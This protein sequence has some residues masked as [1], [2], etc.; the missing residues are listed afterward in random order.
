[1]VLFLFYELNYL[2]PI[3]MTEVRAHVVLHQKVSLVMTITSDHGAPYYADHDVGFDHER[4]VRLS[5]LLSIYQYHNTSRYL[6]D[7]VF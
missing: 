4:F 7:Y 6:L 5:L 1:M 3:L 2:L